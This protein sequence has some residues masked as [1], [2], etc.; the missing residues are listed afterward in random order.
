MQIAK[1]ASDHEVEA[2]VVCGDST[3]HAHPLP[4]TLAALGR[5]AGALDAAGIS[6]V[7]VAGN[8]DPSVPAVAEHFVGTQQV[9]LTPKVIRLGSV[10]VACLP[11]LPDRFVRAQVGGT[12][13]REEVS[14]ALTAA[15]QQIVA[16]LAQQRRP[17]IPLVFAGHGT[18]AGSETSVGYQMG[19]VPEASWVLYPR[20]LEAFD[21]SAVGHIHRHQAFTGGVVP[22]SMLP[23][24]FSEAEPK[25]VVIADVQPGLVNWTFMPL[26]TP[27]V[28]TWDISGEQLADFAAGRFP[29][30]EG[31]KLRVRVRCDEETAR[32]YPPSRIAAALYEAGASLVQVDL[33]VERA[34]RARDG[35]MTDELRPEVALARWAAQ[36]GDATT[37]ALDGAIKRLAADVLAELSP[38]GRSQQSDLSLVAIEAQDFIGV[39]DARID[40]DGHGIY[41][42]TG[43]VGVGKSTLG[44]DAPRFALFAASRA[45]SKPSEMLIRQGADSARAS[46]ELRAADGSE[47]RIVR[48][49]KRGKSGSVTSAVDVLRRRDGEWVPF[50]DDAKVRT[51]K[52]AVEQ[53]LGGLSDETL[54]TANFVVQGESDSFT[55][56]KPEDRRRLIAEAAGLSVYDE[57][58]DAS[59]DHLRERVR[60]LE[61]LHAKADPLR[62]RARQIPE[63][64]TEYGNVEKDL[65]V[66]SLNLAGAQ[67]LYEETREAVHKAEAD[68]V[69]Y[70]ALTR[71]QDASANRRQQVET[72][73]AAWRKKRAAATTILAEREAL[74]AAREELAHVRAEIGDLLLRQEREN[75]AM[76]ERHDAE[77]ARNELRRRIDAMAAERKAE[78]RAIAAQIEAAEA[79]AALVDD[80]QGCPVLLDIRANAIPAC[81]LL[82]AAIAARESLAELTQRLEATMDPTKDE[83]AL[84]WEWGRIEVPDLPPLSGVVE[85]ALASARDREADLL[86]KCEI[87]D[88]VAK[89]EEIVAQYAEAVAPL[90]AELATITA[91]LERIGARLVEI[92]RAH[93]LLAQARVL[94]TSHENAVEDGELSLAAARDRLAELRGRLAALREAATELESVERDIT[95]IAGE[96][97]AW[98]ELVRAWQDCRVMTLETS[99]I[100]AI[101][102]TANDV[103]RR[104][105]YGLQIAFATQREKKASDGVSEALDITVL[106]GHGPV[107]EMCSGGQ[108]SVIDFAL[109][110]A[111]ALVVSRRAGSR[112]RFM[113]VDEPAFLDDAGYAA[114]A[115]VVR[116]VHAEFGITCVVSSHVADLISAIGGQE[117]RVVPGENGSTLEVV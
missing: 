102:D 77:R 59:R 107:Y 34:D 88:K 65:Q 64:E 96:V 108:R 10:D 13:T 78:E 117:L 11:Y 30:S 45:G 61:L 57:L 7:W 110:I 103:L 23:L 37:Y 31:E 71:Y 75:A 109:H 85:G 12:A 21:F 36:R 52:V 93:A 38:E 66:A 79:Q 6:V 67:A 3:H 105:P 113:F 41:T 70:D 51:G 46:V 63:L 15:A 19:F 101:E 60:S 89:A 86:R 5:L 84:A 104:F 42:L 24:D 83:G 47:Y 97:T 54:T 2:V 44:T 115:G 49:V 80:V 55:R 112:L 95:E 48:K 29:V 25:G 43:P 40:F 35:G 82:G 116:W 14:T 26:E 17:G 87:A 76:R 72:D 32:A 58:A 50:A 81:S 114:F 39:H 69:E 100:P 62:S 18:I 22:G 33:T 91:D 16:G 68:V 56:A 94:L 28:S 9:A 27:H 90:D 20:D 74:I 106:G 4:R 8:H 99:V 53:I 98:K 92:G 1:V 111:I 73:L